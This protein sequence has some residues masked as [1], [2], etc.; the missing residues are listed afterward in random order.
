MNK[1]AMWHMELNKGLIPVLELCDGTLLHESRVLM[2]FA[3]E[4]GGDSGIQ[5]Y[6]R[7]P[8]EAAK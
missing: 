6:S 2:E 5:L 8:V 4:K 3:N 1:K 7:D